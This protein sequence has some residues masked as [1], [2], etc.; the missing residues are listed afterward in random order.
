MKCTHCNG[1]HPADFRFCPVTGKEIEN[2]TIYDKFFPVLDLHLGAT[3]NDVVAKK[4]LGSSR[5]PY[6][7]L[8]NDIARPVY[9]KLSDDDQY[10]L[11]GYDDHLGKFCNCMFFSLGNYS[12]L[13][14]NS[15]YALP[16]KWEDLGFNWHDSYSEWKKLLE[17]MN[18]IVHD[19]IIEF[20]DDHNI[21]AISIDETIAFSISFNFIG[22]GHIEAMT[23]SSESFN[24]HARKFGL[25]FI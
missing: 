13:F 9:G 4:L 19:R 24:Y 14:I 1:E 8:K 3:A 21:F 2:S 11:V 12:S 22:V 6:I 10:F 15:S 23:C 16:R 17:Q 7:E 18:F 25:L 5:Y 20:T